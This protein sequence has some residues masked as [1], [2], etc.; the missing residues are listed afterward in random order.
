MN[1]ND[2]DNLNLNDRLILGFEYTLILPQLSNYTARI[3]GNQKGPE[4]NHLAL[5][6]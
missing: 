6:T 3:I 5:V 2:M 4:T 1:V